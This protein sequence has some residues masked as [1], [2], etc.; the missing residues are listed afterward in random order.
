MQKQ[1]NGDKSSVMTE[2]HD[3]V[4]GQDLGKLYCN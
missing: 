2:K 1:A 4:E 3:H